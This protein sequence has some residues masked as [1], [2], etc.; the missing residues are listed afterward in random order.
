MNDPDDV[1]VL[2]W[3]LSSSPSELLYG[4]LQ[5]C[6]LLIWLNM[7]HFRTEKAAILVAASVG[8]ALAPLIGNSYGQ[9]KYQMPLS[10]TKTMEGSIVGVFLG[11]VAM[12]YMFL[13]AMGLDIPHWRCIFVYGTIASTV[14]GSSPG[15]FD[16]VIVPLVVHFSMDKVEEWCRRDLINHLLLYLVKDID[17]RFD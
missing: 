15:N 1:D 13:S 8:D 5:L 9:H 11:T 7:Y 17:F 3:S 12:S 14:E 4:P 2:N 16:N 6:L 10:N